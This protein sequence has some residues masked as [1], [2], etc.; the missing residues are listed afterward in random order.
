MKFV[1]SGGNGDRWRT[2]RTIRDVDSRDD[3]RVKLASGA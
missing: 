1:L 2:W 3:E